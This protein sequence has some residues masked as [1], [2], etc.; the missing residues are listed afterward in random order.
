MVSTPRC[1]LLCGFQGAHDVLNF[2]S[3]NDQ[4]DPNRDPRPRKRF[5]SS[6]RLVQYQYPRQDLASDTGSPG[7][8]TNID[9]GT[10]LLLSDTATG[11]DGLATRTRTRTRTQSSSEGGT[12]DAASSTVDSGSSSTE[13]VS[14]SG[15]VTGTACTYRAWQYPSLTAFDSILDADFLSNDPLFPQLIPPGALQRT[16]ELQLMLPTPCPPTKPITTSNRLCM[17]SV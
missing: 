10:S 3:P 16:F 17:V 1:K 6:P 15:G 13:A 9:Q 8:S 12:S 4:D 2:F 5:R 14:D 7:L 11:S